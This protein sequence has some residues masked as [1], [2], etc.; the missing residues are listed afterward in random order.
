MTVKGVLRRAAVA[1]LGGILCLTLV[2]CGGA[3]AGSSNEEKALSIR[4][5]YIGAVSIEMTVALK[6]DYGDRVYEYTLKYTGDTNSGE[7]EVMEP[8][9]IAGLKAEVSNSDVSLKY[10]GAVLDTG[11]ITEDGMTP[12]EAIPTMINAWK[13]GYISECYTEKLDET[14]TLVIVIDLSE[15]LSQRTWFDVTTNLPV[16]SETVSGEFVVIECKFENAL[17]G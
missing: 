6:A 3:L 7:L 13:S 16:K 9:I 8:E 17:L 4:A 11:A 10:D 5:E 14:N 2:S 1:A 12:I 15:G